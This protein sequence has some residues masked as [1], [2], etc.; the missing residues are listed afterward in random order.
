MKIAFFELEN[1]QQK[2]FQ[3][4]L[5]A[6]DELVFVNKPLKDTVPEEAKDAEVFAIFIYSQITGNILDQAK[7]LRLVTTLSTGFDHIDLDACKEKNI[8]V[9]NV[10]TYGE[11]TVA[12]HTFALIFA[13]SKRIIESYKQVQDGQ[14]TPEGLTTFDLYKKTLG[15]VGVG[16]IGKHVIKIA[17]GVGMNVIGYKRSPDPS[18]ESELDFKLVDMDTLLKQSD[19]I[20]L[21][22]PYTKATHHLITEHEFRKMKKGV[23][24]I[25]TSRGAVIDT[26]A[27]IKNLENKKVKAAGL[28]VCEGENI[29]RDESQVIH[30]PMEKEELMCALETH[31]LQHFPNVVMTPHNAFNSKEALIRILDTSIENI[32]AFEK[33]KP[34]NTVEAK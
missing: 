21:H 14:F 19:I 11:I 7:N 30:K 25:N 9:T 26:T 29:L 10:P 13:C 4:K 12:E 32:Q 16:N 23:I 6:E 18:L 1:W 2:Y 22:V 20:T 8:S 17:K 24:I 5:G 33:N 15:V 3:D 34:Q 28:D 27:L 31:L